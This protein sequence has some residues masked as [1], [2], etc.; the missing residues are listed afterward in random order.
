MALKAFLIPKERRANAACQ[1]ESLLIGHQPKSRT[2]DGHI[3]R[4]GRRSKDLGQENV[5]SHNGTKYETICVS[6]FLLFSGGASFVISVNFYF[7]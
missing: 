4:R 6:D 1:S 5:S 7:C 2:S 3:G